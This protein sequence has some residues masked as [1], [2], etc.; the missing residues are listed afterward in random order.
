[1]RTEFALPDLGEGIAEGE[2]VAWHVEPGDEVEEDELIAEVETDKALVDLPSPYDGTI[3]ELQAEEGEIV[4]VKDVLVVFDVDEDDAPAADPAKESTESTADA[5]EA[6]ASQQRVFAPP[7]VRRLAR[8]EGVDLTTVEPSGD[9]ISAQDVHQ[10]ASSEPA[11]PTEP[12]A[13]TPKPTSVETAGA[14]DR[15]LA[16]PATRKLARQEDVDIDNVPT[17]RERDGEAFV[18]PEEVR[19]FVSGEQSTPATDTPAAEGPQPGDRIPYTG[20]RRTIGERMAESKFT[21]PH[22]SH[23]DEVAVSSLVALRERLKPI[24]EERG[25]KL[26]YLPFAVKAVCVALQQVPAINAELDEEAE[27]IILHDNYNIGIAVAADEGLMVPVID[28]VDE[29]GLLDI[30]QEINDKAERARNRTIDV[31]ELQGGTFTITNIGPIGGEYASPIINYPEA[32]ILALG[33]MKE[34]PWVEDGE[35]VARPTIP[36]S[37]TSDHRLVDGAEAAMFTNT[38]KQYLHDPELLLLE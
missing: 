18:T 17:S 36:I 6:D 7:R 12:T 33:E 30:A 1:M 31:D 32:A 23:H 5:T 24:A 21:A 9:R 38:I 11:E 15:T 25:V 13:E 8:E 20:V 27:E 10:A 28:N 4:P 3:A 37:M 19:A 29:K 2:L 22:V 34:R 26:T 14:R 35:V 16:V